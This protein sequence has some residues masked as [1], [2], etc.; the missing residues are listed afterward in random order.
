MNRSGA[1]CAIAAGC[2]EVICVVV[3]SERFIQQNQG[4]IIAEALAVWRKSP[5]S[6]MPPTGQ[7]R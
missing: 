2:D 4:T 5:V 7:Q 1:E 3:A 6:S